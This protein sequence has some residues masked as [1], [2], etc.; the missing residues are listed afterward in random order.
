MY[1]KYYVYQTLNSSLFHNYGTEAA[2]ICDNSICVL[3]LLIMSIPRM[4]L[5]HSLD[6]YEDFHFSIV[7]NFIYTML[8][9]I[10]CGSFPSKT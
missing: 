8:D 4:N 9:N 5:L 6:R 7:I 2:N 1:T 3:Q 10:L